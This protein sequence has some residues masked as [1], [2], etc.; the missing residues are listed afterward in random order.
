MLFRKDFQFQAVEAQDPYKISIEDWTKELDKSP[1]SKP[2]FVLINSPLL[3][4]KFPNRWPT[5]EEFDGILKTTG[6]YVRTLNARKVHLLLT[7]I[8]DPSEMF[9]L[10]K[11]R[12]LA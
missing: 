1:D 3:F 11:I 12:I 6:D 2:E 8:K 9:V 4:D 7:D 5:V 10:F